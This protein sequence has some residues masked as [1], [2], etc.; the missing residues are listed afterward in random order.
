MSLLPTRAAANLSPMS[1]FTENLEENATRVIHRSLGFFVT[2]LVEHLPDGGQRI[3]HSRWHRKGLP[4]I[5]LASGGKAL[6]VMMPTTSPW[7]QLWAPLKLA[8]WIAILFVIGSACFAVASFAANWP[9]YCPAALV[10][11]SVVNTVFFAGSLFFTAAAGLQLEEAINGDLADMAMSSGTERPRWRWL[12]WKPRN[13]GFS[14]SF[15]QFIGT[16]LFNLNTGDAMLSQLTWLQEEILIWTPDVIGSICF[17]ASSYLALVEVSHR[18]C[19]Y[20]PRQLSWWIVMI[21]LLGS[22]AFMVAA[23]FDYF[24]PNSGNME[25]SWGANFYTLLG[26]LCFFVASYLMIPEQAGAGRSLEVPPALAAAKAT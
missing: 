12:A 3:S 2:R 11:G 19:S 1:S 5:E 14:A 8:W 4:P 20:Q 21:N 22:I 15:I 7:L 10:H 16:L 9:G 18:V 17:L 26:A 23:L 24:V 13:A 25:W 6:R